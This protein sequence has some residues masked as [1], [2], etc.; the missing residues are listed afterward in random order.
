MNLLERVF[1]LLRA[2]LTN[3]AEKSDDP[4]KMLRQLQLDMRNQLVQVKTQVATAIAEGMKLQKRNK[5]QQ[6]EATQW[7]KKAEQAIQ[8]NNENAA[9]DFLARYNGQMRQSLRYQ[10]QQ[11]EQE[12]FVI[13]M[14][15]ILRQLEAKISEVDT[16][17][18]LLEARKRNAL[19][20][21][22]IYDTLSKSGSSK[23]KER[24]LRAQDAL[25]EIEA[26]ARALAD[27][28]ERDIDNQL[29]QLSR[30]KLIEEQIQRLKH[31]KSQAQET[32][33]LSEEQPHA[34]ELAAPP[35]RKSEPSR[36]RANGGTPADG[37]AHTPPSISTESNQ[38]LDLEKLRKLMEK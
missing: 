33:L 8:Q 24:A 15:G 3:M 1:A 27:I 11:K 34:S 5:E 2:N 18:E 14:R 32:P 23:D 38:E 35:P 28:Q 17:I 10:Q 4:E 19:R 30:E 12:Q 37:L 25:L 20:Q 7:L 21:Q 9:R 26:R 29:E 22:R 13:T 6:S 31:K 36:K 16:T